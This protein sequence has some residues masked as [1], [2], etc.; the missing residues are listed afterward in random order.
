MCFALQEV[1][2]QMKQLA[3]VHVKKECVGCVV[4]LIKE[5]YVVLSLPKF[6]TILAIAQTRD[7]NDISK[8]FLRFKYGQKCK[9]SS[10]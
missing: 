2:A 3:S 4:E 9:I 7:T 8:P 5:N 1:K 10:L 6:P